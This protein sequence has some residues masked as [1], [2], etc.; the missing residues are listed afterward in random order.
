MTSRDPAP[1]TGSRKRHRSQAE[2]RPRDSSVDRPAKHVKHEPGSRDALVKHALLAQYYS[3]IKTLRQYA[4][5]KLPP[6]SRLRRK[7]LASVG[8]PHPPLEEPLSE[9]E[10]TLG[11]LLDST[12]VAYRQHAAADHDVRWQQWT[13]FSQRGD[14]SAVTLSDGLR[15]SIYSQSEVRK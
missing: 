2:T 8:L 14:E 9:A 11:H 4:L 5:S 1:G 7:K 6:S 13:G 15:G 10:L 3:E 12:L